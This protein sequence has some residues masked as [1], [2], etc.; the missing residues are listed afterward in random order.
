[1]SLILEALGRSQQEQAGPLASFQHEVVPAPRPAKPR[2]LWLWAL[3]LAIFGVAVWWLVF[4]RQSEAPVPGFE[5]A[6]PPVAEVVQ[7]LAK[8]DPVAVEKEAPPPASKPDTSA[9]SAEVAALYAQSRREASRAA[10]APKRETKPAPAKTS[11]TPASAQVKDS[12]DTPIDVEAMLAKA[13]AELRQQGTVEH[14]APWLSELSQR[15]RDGIP[16]LYYARHDY[17]KVRAQRRVMLNK[18]LVAEG[19][20]VPGSAVKVEEILPDSVV[21]SHSGLTFRLKALNS[22]VNL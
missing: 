1:M 10:A 15:Q 18:S 19:R 7:P 14:S 2:L 12:D 5:Q 4:G 6:P 3:L 13:Q 20:V 16:T 22:W 17:S 21:L 9:A 11:K 8:A